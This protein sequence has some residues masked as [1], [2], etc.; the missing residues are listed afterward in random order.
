MN[1]HQTL[2]FNK[3]IKTYKLNIKAQEA[4]KYLVN[5]HRTPLYVSFVNGNMWFIGR[6]TLYTLMKEKGFTWDSKNEFWVRL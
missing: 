3:I 6:N 1:E 2:A 5:N 4:F